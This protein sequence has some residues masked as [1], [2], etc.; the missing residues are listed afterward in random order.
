M[1]HNRTFAVLVA[2]ILLVWAAVAGI[3]AVAETPARTH[4]IEP[5]DYFSIGVIAQCAVAPDGKQVA[6]TEVRWGGPD[7]RRTSDL[8]VVDC[9][10]KE[11]RRLTFERVGAGN[12]AWSPD[13][14]YIYFTARRT[15]AGEEKPPFDGSAQVW[16]VGPE[17]GEPLAVTRIKDGVGG[18]ELARDGKHLLYTKSHKHVDDDPWKALRE[19]YSDLEYGHGVTD[20]HQVWELDL[21][22]WTEKK[23]VDDQRVIQSMALAPDGSKLAMITTPD[24]QLVSHEGWSRLDVYDFETEEVAQLTGPDWR[25][26]HPSPYGWL[27]YPA[28][29]DDSQALAFMIS[30]D[31]YPSEI[32]VAEWEGAKPGI[33]KLDRAPEL[34]I[35]DMGAPSWL[36]KGRDLC[37]VA[38][39]RARVRLYSIEDVRNG[40]QGKL[41]VLTPGDVVIHS[42]SVPQG[43]HPIAVVKSTT[44]ETRDIFLV[45][46]AGAFEQITEVNPQVATWKLPQ[47]SIVSWK[48]ARGDDVEGILELPPDY[49]PGEGPLPMVVEL[50]GGP[51][52][53]TYYRLRFWIYGR[54]LLAAKGYA[55]LSPNYRGSTGYGDDFMTDL[56][57]HENDIEIEDILTGIDAMVERGIAD[58][59]R[60]GVV[61]WSNGGL[62]TNC[63]ITHTQ[64]FKAASTG[65]GI[66][67]MVLQW[68]TEDTPGHVV[69]YMQGLPWETPD[70]YRKASAVYALDRVTTPTLI[71]VGGSDE[72]CPPAH[73][74]GLYR[75]LHRYLK[76]PTELVIYPG[77]GHGL[78]I[79]QNRLAKMEWDLAWFDKYL[80]GKEG[81]SKE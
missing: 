7:E 15:R 80:L 25:R 27:E 71:H 67:D 74:K 13:S 38:E 17:G 54:T 3:P 76:V 30:Y 21:E 11:R 1:L 4:E 29:S 9:N 18:F 56:V 78:L 26:N 20:F 40:K 51:T 39:E 43:R 79:R 48:G 46:H 22:G 66:L 65:A 37:F 75:A 41:R 5:E 45:T 59:E 64:R 16:R 68:G 61:G 42:Y 62:L 69:N 44:T 33:R 19:Q 28:W 72:R 6:Y 57:G 77:E 34:T 70:A 14:R 23:L 52:A 35:S 47:I 73:S 55:L 53:A 81:E 12:L 32:Y 31:G 8:W 2:G 24:D 50:H 10:S 36:P 49:Q 60:L 58:P 63:I